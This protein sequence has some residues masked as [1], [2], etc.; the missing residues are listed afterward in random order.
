MD[1]RLQN[2]RGEGVKIF[3]SVASENMHIPKQ[4]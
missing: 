2:A 1:I 3:T 4:G